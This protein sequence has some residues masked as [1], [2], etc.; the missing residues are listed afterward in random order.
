MYLVSFRVK[1]KMPIQG[2]YWALGVLTGK[3]EE[4][5]IMTHLTTFLPETHLLVSEPD[6]A[7]IKLC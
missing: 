5:N 7:D 4:K 2:V 6:P 1:G 3:G